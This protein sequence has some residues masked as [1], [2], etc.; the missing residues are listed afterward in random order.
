MPI[1]VFG[2]NH[3]T[4]PIEVRE[5]LFVSEETI[6]RLVREL[7]ESGV[8]EN[9]VL[10]TCNRTEFYFSCKNLDSALDK[11]YQA[12]SRHFSIEKEWLEKYTYLLTDEDT[13]RHLFLVA[14]GLDSMVVGEPQILGQVKDAY[15]L[16]TDCNTSGFFL[17]KVF[18]K[19]FNV[20]KRIRT[21]TKVGY[22]P[23]SISA[24]AIEL[25]KKIFGELKDKK[26]LVIGAGEMCEIALRYFKK[27]GVGDIYITNRTFHNAQK[28]ADE[29]TGIPRPFNDLQ[30][31]LEKVDMIL[32]STG[33]ER[34]LISREL[35]SVVMKKRKQKPLF[36]IDIAV[37]RD[38]EPSVNDLENVYLY[39]ID[40]LKELSQQHLSDRLAESEKARSI[41]DEEVKKFSQWLRQLDK[42]PL[43]SNIYEKVEEIRSR[44]LKKILQKNK[45][46]DDETMKNMDLL[47]KSIVN[48]LVHPHVTMIK[49]NGSPAILEL[50]KKLFRLEDDDE[51]DV[52]SWHK[53]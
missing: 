45:N 35:V 49:E 2:L 46:T 30:D 14:S 44:E 6:P 5:R 50:M 16:A 26:T 20:A 3:N 53:G 41:V 31:L 8:D 4:A 13:Y 33:S 21:E 1:A 18:H 47:T 24:M 9:I 37:P 7:Q 36:F 28:L 17:D 15:R 27:E 25:A 23:V 29:T 22:N 19:T 32:S 12:L 51:Q 48:K 42:N 52:D 38:I 10:S 43:I 11:F 34:P 39:D 40:D